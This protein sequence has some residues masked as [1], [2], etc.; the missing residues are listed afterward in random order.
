MSPQILF[1]AVAGYILL[2]F[3]AALISG[4]KGGNREFFTGNRSS[5]W[6][7]V[8]FA[9]TG[10]AMSGVTFVSVPGMVITEGFSYMQMALG[11][12][13]GQAVVAF[14]LVPLFYRLQVRSI[15]G[16][17]LSRFG[18]GTQ[19][20]GAWLFF[21]AKLLSAAVKLFLACAV[22]QFLFLEQWGMPFAAN[23]AVSVMLVF[24]YTLHGGVKSVIWSDVLKTSLML[25]SVGLCIWTISG[26]LGLSLPEMAESVADSELSQ[27]FFFDDWRDW[28]YFFKL[29]LAGIFVLVAMTGLDQDMMQRNLS[30][31]TARD[32][33]KNIMTAAVLQTAV[34]MMFLVLGV[35]LCNYAAVAGV[36]LPEASDNIF[37]MVATSTQM[38]AAVG[39]MFVLGLVSA[40][41]SSTGSAMT[42]LTTSLT[43]DILEGG[44]RFD[45]RSL[46]R[47]RKCVHGG[48][49][50]A[51]FAVVMLLERLGNTSVIDAVY[52][53]ASYTYGPILGLFAFGI[54]TRRQIHDRW[55]GVVAIASPAV[56]YILQANSGRW[57][58]GYELGYELLLLN[59]FLTFAG[60]W[61]VSR[62]G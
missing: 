43:L 3:A 18:T 16:Y 19:H 29:F 8:A 51:I 37:P 46:A 30:C 21:T 28:R 33:Q 23:A 27:L 36:E 58:G 34:I 61:A 26:R 54:L 31:R 35:L 1:L 10:G 22:M 48:V 50:A 47:V 17:L 7:V 38:P 42:A 6:W 9:M 4:R 56:C 53:L 45:E 25:A 49:A 14:V 52:T 55:G 15:Y 57:F 40:T 44:R 11:F 41:F 20:M 12:L 62:K 60:L 39:V 5:R 13:A 2:L 32:A 24:L 59:A